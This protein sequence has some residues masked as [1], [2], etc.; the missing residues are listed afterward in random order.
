MKEW[1][2]LIAMLTGYALLATLIITVAKY[3]QEKKH[4]KHRDSKRSL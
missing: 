4:G 3:R 1:L 2:W